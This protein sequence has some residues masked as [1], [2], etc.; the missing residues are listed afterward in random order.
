MDI[1]EMELAI[2]PQDGRV[3]TVPREHVLLTAADTDSATTELAT[4]SMVGEVLIALNESFALT[5]ALVMVAART[6][7]VLVMRVGWEMIVH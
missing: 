4:A 1:A 6:S 3:T 7:H 2:A 5:I